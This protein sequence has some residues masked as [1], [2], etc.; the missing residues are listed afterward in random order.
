MDRKKEVPPGKKPYFVL[1]ILNWHEVWL[2]G[3]GERRGGGAD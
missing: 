1:P 2:L 3:G